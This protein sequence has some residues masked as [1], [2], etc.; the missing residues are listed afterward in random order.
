MTESIRGRMHAQSK[1]RSESHEMDATQHSTLST[2]HNDG[3][4]RCDVRRRRRGEGEDRQQLQRWE[5]R[6]R[7]TGT[8]HAQHRDELVVRCAPRRQD[9]AGRCKD[10]QRR[11]RACREV[12]M[13]RAHVVRRCRIPCAL[14]QV[15]AAGWT[16]G[17]RRGHPSVD[18]CRW[19]EGGTA[20]SQTM[21]RRSAAACRAERY[22]RRALRCVASAAS[23]ACGVRDTGGPT[24]AVHRVRHTRRPTLRHAQRACGAP[25]TTAAVPT[26]RP[27]RTD[28]F[29]CTPHAPFAADATQ[30]SARRP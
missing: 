7:D 30:R 6:T 13:Q 2:R 25:C 3:A 16:G 1:E 26:V 27:A 8:H 19:A 22:G 21:Q 11:G 24:D 20:H 23:R 17:R 12:G 9:R 14:R 29:R 10:G 5:T 28:A 18:A 4:L 15:T